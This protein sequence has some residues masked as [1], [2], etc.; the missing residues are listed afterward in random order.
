MYEN[1]PEPKMAKNPEHLSMANEIANALIDR[2]SPN[3][4][5]EALKSIYQTI[6]NHRQEMIDKAEKEVAFL[7]ETFSQLS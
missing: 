2:L 7:K 1:N 5:N 3:E 6:K 4:Q